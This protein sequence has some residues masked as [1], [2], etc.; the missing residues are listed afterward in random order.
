MYLVRTRAGA[1]QVVAGR[2]AA[3]AA[4]VPEAEARAVLEDFHRGVVGAG[5]GRVHSH[6]NLGEK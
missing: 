4:R 1:V 5:A 3:V 2:A 6:L